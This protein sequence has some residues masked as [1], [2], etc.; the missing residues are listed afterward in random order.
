VTTILFAP[1]S[2]KGSVSAVR[3]TECLIDGWREIRPTDTTIA[4]PMADGGE[5]T[6]DV[7]ASIR[8]D[9]T[10]MTHSVT[11][12]DGRAVEAS[13]LML[14]DQTAVIEL[15]RSSGLPLMSA[16]NPVGATT[17]GLGELI[18]HALD[19]GAIRILV[20][21]GGSATTDAGLGALEALGARVVRADSSTTGALGVDSIDTS[22]LRTPPPEGITIL[23][24]TRELFVKAPEVFG[25]Q[26]GATSEEVAQLRDAFEA[27]TTLSPT[28]N[29]DRMSGSGAA[30][31]CAWALAAFMRG[32]II[33]G[34]RYLGNMLGAGR[35]LPD[36]DFVITGEGRLDSTSTK[37]KVVGYLHH[38]ATAQSVPGAVVAGVCDHPEVVSWPVIT[39]TELAAQDEDAI[40]DS[41]ELL[42]RAGAKLAK[43]F[44]Q[45]T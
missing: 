44:S 4:L 21:L 8:P 38:L 15:A 41:E 17:F 22:V 24:D 18:A 14:S 20:A 9:H 26:K 34:S 32:V 33:E 25:P 35:L 42:R 31:G 7:V 11:G 23:A 19:Q 12:P 28:P 6:L 43:E 5:G 1:D 30:G 40:G 10:W 37:G 45:R 29:I 3:A 13:W 39:L 16:P 36:M 2:Y 27:L